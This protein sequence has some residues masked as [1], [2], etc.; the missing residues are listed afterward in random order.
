M[1]Y[2]KTL[3]IASFTIQPNIKL[4]LVNISIPTKV[5]MFFGNEATQRA[6]GTPAAE[7]NL[8]TTDKNTSERLCGSLF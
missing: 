2:Y 8:K 1:G 7:K 3:K 5:I 4:L 6:T